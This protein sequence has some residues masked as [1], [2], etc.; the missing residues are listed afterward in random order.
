MGATLAI[1]FP[2]IRRRQRL[3]DDRE[4]ASNVPKD[5]VSSSQRLPFRFEPMDQGLRNRMLA[6]YNE[7][8]SEYEEAYT[9]GTGTASI[10]DPTVFTTEIGILKGIVR[11][12][13]C[14]HLLDLACGTGF[15]LPHYI[16]NC[17]NVTLFDQSERMLMECALKVGRLEGLL[18]DALWFEV[19]SSTIR[20]QPRRTTQRWSVSF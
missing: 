8:A 6:Y 1:V 20:S 14:G 16:A 19:M 11:R 5:L 2:L 3:V 18:T 10:A 17:V 9:L 7:R 15:W 4:A 13:G 12:F